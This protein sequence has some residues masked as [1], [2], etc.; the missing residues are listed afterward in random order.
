MNKILVFLRYILFS[1]VTLGIYPFYFYV[2]R[3]ELHTKLLSEML[4]ELKKN[5]DISY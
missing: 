5:S 1:I 2:T 4:D 3:T